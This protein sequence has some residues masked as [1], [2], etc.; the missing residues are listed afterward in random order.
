LHQKEDG[1][2]SRNCKPDR[3]SVDGLVL[4]EV[5]HKL[6][7]VLDWEVDALQSSFHVGFHGA[8]VATRHV[9][10]DIHAPR[11][12]LVPD[13]C[14]RLRNANACDVPQQHAATIGSVD[15]QVLNLG[16]IVPKLGRAP[17]HHVEHLLLVE[18]ASHVDP[19]QQ[20][21]SGSAHVA[22]NDS[23]SFGLL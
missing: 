19:R 7:V 14:R 20:G 15:R 2:N 12:G 9:G 11:D 18:Q 23:D 10:R 16:Q 6:G 4:R 1:D 13:D 17:H 22:G 21:R 5:R 8:E 3:F